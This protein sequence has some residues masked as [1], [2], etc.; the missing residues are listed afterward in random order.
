MELPGVPDDLL[1]ELR[2]AALSARVP[3]LALVGGA[4]RDGLLHQRNGG[5]WAG[6]PDLDLVVEGSAE[7]LAEAIQKRCGADRV[8]ELRVHGNYGTVE[9]VLDGVS[10]DLAMARQEYAAAAEK[11]EAK[12]DAEAAAATEEEAAHA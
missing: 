11:E 8:S 4:V 3:R 2:S 10:L 1:N 9:L 5:A 12:K 6:V 7:A